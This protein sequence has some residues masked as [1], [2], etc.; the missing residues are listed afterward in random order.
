MSNAD[1]IFSKTCKD[2]LL[3]GASTEGY[4]CRTKWVDTGEDAYTIKKFGVVNEY[5]L[6]E[7]FPALTLRKTN[8]KAAIDEILW[9]YQ[10]RSNNTSL[11]N[12]KIWDQWTDESGTIG[13][14]YGYQIAK[15]SLI[16]VIKLKNY[17]EI[18]NVTL[19][20]NYHFMS[21][22][23][24]EKGVYNLN[25]FYDESMITTAKEKMIFVN[26]DYD[27]YK[28]SKIDTKM[29]I[30]IYAD[31]INYVLNQLRNNPLSRRIMMNMYNHEDSYYMMLQPC[32]YSCLF[33][34]TPY[35]D[36]D[37]KTTFILDMILNQRSQD[38]LVAGNWNVVQ[39]AA[40]LM[41]IA[42]TVDMVPGKLIHVIGDCHIYDRHVPVIKQMLDPECYF[43]EAPKVRFVPG[44]CKNF[45]KYTTDM[46][47]VDNYKYHDD[48]KN[49][50][51]AK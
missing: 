23:I 30:N 26:K 14:A 13:R 34:V 4:P 1:L 18:G 49:I 5:D 6:S 17:I 29:K 15:L 21:S 10:K 50:P 46:F 38:M 16:E 32:A 22:F 28:L 36:D 48:I 39:Y 45:F 40:L 43:Y 25:V 12:S 8:I 31:Q 27:R 33:N 20:D 37:G 9:I 11:L 3:N 35:T 41:M 42:H 51:V 24:D 19:G 7:E 2:I 44:N 47:A